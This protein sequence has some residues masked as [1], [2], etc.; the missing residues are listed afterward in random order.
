MEQVTAYNWAIYNS[1]KRSSSLNAVLIPKAKHCFERH[2]EYESDMARMDFKG[3]DNQCEQ[4]L[5]V[6][7]PAIGCILILQ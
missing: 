2:I 1:Y 3:L 7:A 5:V 6:F 4:W